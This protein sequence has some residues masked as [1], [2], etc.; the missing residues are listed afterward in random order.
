MWNALNRH[1]RD[2]FKAGTDWEDTFPLRSADGRYNWFLS[3]AL[4]ICEEP[5][6]ANP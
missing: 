3:R 5:D 2:S 6:E 4:P 1:L